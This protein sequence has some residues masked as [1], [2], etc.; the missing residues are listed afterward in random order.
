MARPRPSSND[1]RG[2]L[3]RTPVPIASDRHKSPPQRPALSKSARLAPP[4]CRMDGATPSNQERGQAEPTRPW[5]VGRWEVR[6]RRTLAS[7]VGELPTGGRRSP[8]RRLF[9]RQSTELPLHLWEKLFASFAS[10]RFIVRVRTVSVFS[11]CLCVSVVLLAG[12]TP[13]C[14][15]WL[16][17]RRSR[18]PRCS[19][20]SGDR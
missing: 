13:R 7:G 6:R 18:H 16:P 14:R 19:R 8:D 11:L 20:S 12:P 5:R 1:D 3:R 4:F 2:P 10:L 15:G 9:R 17:R